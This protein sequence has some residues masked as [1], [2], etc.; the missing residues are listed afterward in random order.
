[1]P[2]THFK[3]LFKI[4]LLFAIMSFLFPVVCQG[5]LDLGVFSLLLGAVSAYLTP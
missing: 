5:Q 4:V 1:M 2:K 3:D